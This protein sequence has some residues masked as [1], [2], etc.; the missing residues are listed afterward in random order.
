MQNYG[1][2]KGDQFVSLEGR[3]NM[4]FSYADNQLSQRIDRH[5]IP[6]YFWLWAKGSLAP[7]EY[8]L[9][10][11]GGDDGFACYVRGSNL[12]Y[13]DPDFVGGYTDGL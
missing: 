2:V 12:V 6:A 1:L 7:I 5:F 3:Q 4:S 10:V 13:M 9:V 8:S 11:R